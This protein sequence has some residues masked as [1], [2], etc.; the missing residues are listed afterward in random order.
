MVMLIIKKKAKLT[1]NKTKMNESLIAK[2]N[3]L[4][5]EDI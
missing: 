5:Q 1:K 3:K 4:L 2:H